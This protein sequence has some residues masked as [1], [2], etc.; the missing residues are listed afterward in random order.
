MLYY[1]GRPA[2]TT[3]NNNT[4]TPQSALLE[5]LPP[6]Q[7]KPFDLLGRPG[8]DFMPSWEEELVMDVAPGV[9]IEQ[10]AL[11]LFEVLQPPS[12]FHSFKVGWR[13]CCDFLMTEFS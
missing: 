2:L 8:M 5:Y 3:V 1:P 6:I 11:L 4:T 12:S 7:T 9:L 10:D 13:V